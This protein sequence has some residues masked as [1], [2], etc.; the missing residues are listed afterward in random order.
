MSKID[1]LTRPDHCYLSD[2]DECFYFGDYT[3]RKG[4]AYSE[5][6]Q[7]ILNLKKSVSRR[8]END[9]R[10]KSQAINVVAENLN[11]HFIKPELVTFIPIPPSKCRNDPLYDDRLVK[12]LEKFHQLN[13]NVDFRDLIVQAQTT[14]ASHDMIHRPSPEE[15]ITLYSINTHLIQG[16]RPH[17][18]IFDDMLTTGSHYKA[19]QELLLKG[20]PDI[21]IYGLFVARRA[22]EALDWEF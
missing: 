14:E 8:N 6:N 9:Y 13:N 15:I 12:I 1:Q 20:I 17:V 21:N 3:A 10:Y 16:I 22:P 7:L 18:I 19:A 4:Y 11:Q 5:T 2:D